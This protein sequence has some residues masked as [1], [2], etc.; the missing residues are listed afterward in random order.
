[1]QTN[2]TQISMGFTVLNSQAT[3]PVDEPTQ[4]RDPG[5]LSRRSGSA[6]K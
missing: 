4:K 5:I 2:Q 3:L 6:A 1:M